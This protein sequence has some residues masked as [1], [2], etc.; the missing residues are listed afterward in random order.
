[1]SWL[2]F[3]YF[4]EVS[5]NP[6]IIYQSPEEFAVYENVCNIEFA[7]EVE[8]FNVVSIGGNAQAYRLHQ[9]VLVEQAVARECSVAFGPAATPTVIWKADTGQTESPEDCPRYRTHLG[10]SNRLIRRRFPPTKNL[11]PLLPRVAPSAGLDDRQAACRVPARGI[12]GA[13]LPSVRCCN[14]YN[15]LV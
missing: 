11:A 2:A 6:G 4:L 15:E 3:L 7:P 5:I 8:L 14:R 9:D 1:M 10:S 13:C 12:P